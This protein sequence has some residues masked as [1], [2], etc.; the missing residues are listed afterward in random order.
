ML[1]V[2]TGPAG[3][4]KD[5]VQQRLLQHYPNLNRVLTTTTRSPRRGEH[6]GDDY[7]FISREEF[8]QNTKNGEFLEYVDFSG[9][10]YGTKK[11]DLLIPLKEGEDL[12]WRIETSRAAN[13]P[14]DLLDKAIVIYL[15]AHNW[16][17]LSDRMRARGTP[18]DKIKERLQ[19]D[20][21]DWEKYRDKFDNVVYN[22]EGKIDKT[23]AQIINLIEFKKGHVLG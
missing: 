22:E 23:M 1:L 18:E 11:N 12:V 16:D 19:K 4:G 13:L 2:I 21:E 3:S 9:N 6:N 20:R 5:T 17:V 10:L 15:N 7:N 8:E 14:Q